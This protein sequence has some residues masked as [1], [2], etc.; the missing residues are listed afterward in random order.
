MSAITGIFYRDGRKVDPELIKKMNNRLSHRGPDGS[1]VW[2]EGLVALGH[3]MLWT[4][5]ESLHEKLPFKDE[6]SGLVITADAR[7][8]NRDKLSN[9]LNIEDKEDVSDSYFILKAYQMWGEDCPDKLLG[10]F[11]FAIWDKNE[12]KLFCARDH[13]GVK[14][15]YYYLSDE[16]FV[17]G[18]E[19]KALFGVPGVPRELNELTIALHLKNRRNLTFY[20]NVLSL[21]AANYIFINKNNLL[22]KRY[23]KLDPM[24]KMEMDS[25]EDYFN[26]FREIFAE[27]INCRLRSAFPIGFDLSGGLDSSSIVCMTKKI[28]KD[29]NSDM[30]ITTFS[31]I[32]EDFPK[33]DERYYINKVIETGGIIPNFVECGN[34]SLLNEIEK[35]LL[36][37]DQPFHNPFLTI[38]YKMMK[39]RKEK[40]IRIHL[41]GSGGDY[42]VSYGDPYLSDLA[43]TFKWNTL[44]NE[45]KCLS[46][47]FNR[48]FYIEFI[49]IL[50][51][52]FTPEYLK[53]RLILIR[54]YLLDILN[55]KKIIAGLNNNFLKDEFIKKVSVNSYPDEKIWKPS[56]RGYNAK[57]HHYNSIFSYFVQENNEILDKVAG[58][59]SIESRYPFFDKRLIEFCY[60]IPTNMKFRYGWD[61]FILRSSMSNILPKEIQCRQKKA[62]LEN[63][64]QKNLL[65]FE[66]D[67]LE[68]M[69]Y[70]HDEIINKYIKLDKVKETFERYNKNG[71]ILYIQLFN[72]WL[73]L[74]LH[75][76]LSLYIKKINE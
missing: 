74:I 66:K 28:L 6:K 42:I 46:K 4:T 24:T 10:D 9:E 52:S 61:R 72:I 76:W 20:K 8:D 16:M 44:I 2:C 11:A 35:I 51:F 59:F 25:D 36:F 12:E 19:I 71:S 26:K 75:K 41:S 13:M 21:R 67:C 30:I 3:Q 57:K 47:Y 27:A 54:I 64:L 23:W 45:I 14:P 65:F 58:S 7:I 43:V 63:V 56:K 73:L 31:Q 5:P 33:A 62:S 55:K 40:D 49:K 69:L 22:K 53:R 1:A 38:L 39:K 17:F 37:Q 50:I 60:A 68:N 15:F 29:N 34:I 32:Y 18:T 70:K 48:N